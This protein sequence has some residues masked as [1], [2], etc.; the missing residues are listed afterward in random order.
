MSQPNR[1][2]TVKGGAARVDA[3]GMDKFVER[4]ADTD[5]ASKR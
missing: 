2:Q 5:T 1:T 3:M 4:L